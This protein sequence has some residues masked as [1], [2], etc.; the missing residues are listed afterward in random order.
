VAEFWAELEAGGRTP[1]AS[2]LA[3]FL[4]CVFGALAHE[5]GRIDGIARLSG[6][7]R[8]QML[9]LLSSAFATGKASMLEQH[10][11][12]ARGCACE[13]SELLQK[14]LELH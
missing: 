12:E 5:L 9:T 11:Q 8:D 14:E 1:E 6:I 13:A 3:Y 4:E 10:R 2:Q 7:D